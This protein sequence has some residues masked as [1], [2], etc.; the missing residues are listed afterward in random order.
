MKRGLFPNVT[1]ALTGCAFLAVA[2]NVHGQTASVEAPDVSRWKTFTN[3]AGWSIK[4]PRD[5]QVSS[6]RSCTDP[7]DP[8]VFVSLY[9][10]TTKQVIMIEPLI[11]KPA[12]Q[13]VEQWL[14]ATQATTNVNPRVNEEWISL[15]G[16]RAL[17][18]I[19]SNRDSTESENI[20]VVHGSKTFAIRADRN[21]PSYQL[22]RQ[23]LSTFRFTGQSKA[24][25]VSVP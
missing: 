14:N 25:S 8:N 2:W 18:V 7:T 3:R 10:T 16:S 12:D 17:K 24:T 22:Y 13:S 23:M 15:D 21:V 20:Y 6:C 11:D 9:N 4:Y 19:N 5:W 1:L